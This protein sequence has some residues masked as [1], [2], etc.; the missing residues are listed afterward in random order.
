MWEEILKAFSLV[1]LPSMVKFIFG[2]MGGYA[3]KLHV[4][5]TI[6]STV[7][8]TMTVVLAFS[9]AGDWIRNNILNRFFPKR[10]RFS[11]RNRKFVTIW[12]KYGVAGVAF[13]TPLLLTPIGGSLLAISFGSPR[14]KLILYMFI[15]ASVWASI[16]SLAIY[17]LGANVFPEYMK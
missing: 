8:G 16:F 4:A 13:L 14:D 2:P 15:S 10:K 9:F 12:K 3:A 1:Y 7:A 5:T 11:E 17:L 6:I